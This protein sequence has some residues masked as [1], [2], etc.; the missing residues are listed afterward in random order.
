MGALLAQNLPYNTYHQKTPKASRWGKHAGMSPKTVW[1]ELPD[2]P[3]I[4]TQ[5]VDGCAFAVP[6]GNPR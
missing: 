5:G 3:T 4:R 2:E 1:G 6:G